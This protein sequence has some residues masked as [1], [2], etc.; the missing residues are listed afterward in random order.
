MDISIYTC[1]YTCIYDLHLHITITINCF[2][3]RHSL[4]QLVQRAPHRRA[5]AQVAQQLAQ[6]GRG[7][8]DLRQLK[9]LLMSSSWKNLENLRKNWEKLGKMMIEYIFCKTH[10][11][12]ISLWIIVYETD[13]QIQEKVA[14]NVWR[15]ELWWNDTWTAQ[16]L[17]P[18]TEIQGCK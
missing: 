13:G 7:A 11:R 8:H 17:G 1:I 5:A 2:P 9:Q 12:F 10:N 15:F 3:G 16:Q 18:N 6:L 14:V 4:R